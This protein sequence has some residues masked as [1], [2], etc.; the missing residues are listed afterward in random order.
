MSDRNFASNNFKIKINKWT[1]HIILVY[2]L[3]KVNTNNQLKQKLLIADLK[4]PTTN[5]SKKQKSSS[6]QSNGT[7]IDP[8]TNIFLSQKKNK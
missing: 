2:K 3:Q 6:Q 1:Q 7:S 4:H 8:T 5:D